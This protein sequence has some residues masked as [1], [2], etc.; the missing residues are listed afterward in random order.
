M[1]RLSIL[2]ALVVLTGCASLQPAPP[3]PPPTAQFVVPEGSE[4]VSNLF[5]YSQAVKVGPWITV[6]AQ[7][8]YDVEKGGFPETLPEQAAMAF[9]NLAAV[10]QA[11]GA[12]LN[13]VVSITSYQLDM[14]QFSDVVDAR[15]EAFGEHRP[16]WTAM[17]VAALPLPVMQFQISAMAYVAAPA[18]AAAA[19]PQAVVSTA[20][21]P[22]PD[23][24]PVT[25]ENKK[26]SPFF[27]RP[28][29]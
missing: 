29:Y 13:D 7:P 17:G 14:E 10:L 28:G 27:N 18:V 12:T 19:P 22:A 21:A 4:F 1:L 6:S 24:M 2:A 9:K 16:T 8:G 3:P 26:T 23:A 20:P 25:A 5:G 15:N 11:S